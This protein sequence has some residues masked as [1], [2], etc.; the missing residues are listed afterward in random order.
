LIGN[1]AS[2]RQESMLRYGR[3]LC[4]GLAEAGHDVTLAAPRCVL[5]RRGRLSAGPDAGIWKWIGYLDKYAAG[6]GELWS[7]VRRADVVHVCDH[8]NAVYIPKRQERPYVTT[9]H[10]MLAVRGALGEATDCPAS[11]TG[12]WLQRGIV[13]G[14]LR[15]A[16]VA[17]VSTATLRD[18]RR[19]LVGYRGL[20]TTVPNALNYPYRRLAVADVRERLRGLRPTLAD[21][22]YV[23]HVGSGHRRKNR[24]CVLRALGEV[25]T[26]WPGRIVFA[27]EPL[28]DEQRALARQLQVTDRVIEI[29]RPSD[30]ILEVLYNGALALF[31]PSRFE[32]FGWPIAE[33]QAAGCAVICSDREPFPEVSGGAAIMCDAD[34]H[35]AFGRAIRLL[36]T[37][38]SEREALVTAGLA[39]S[40]RYERAAMVAKL[41]ALYERVLSPGGASAAA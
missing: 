4:E 40:R 18:A 27:G 21:E 17:C 19:V 13:G 11:P 12:K 34:D 2:D 37:S 41:V 15:A 32:G 36:A 8:G 14:L 9:C 20:L 3:L 33:A 38:P 5:N 16:A 28:T 35:A 31:F 39:N 23:L 1:Y 22:A 7:A 10:D 30:E 29:E 6:V 26:S 25:A 24:E